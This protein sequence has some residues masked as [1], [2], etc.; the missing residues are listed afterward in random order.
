MIIR[1]KTKMLFS[2]KLH[3]SVV[4]YY[5]YCLLP[6]PPRHIPYLRHI[7]MLRIDDRDCPDNY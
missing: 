2:G 5:I 4:P 3:A 6:T 1:A 7:G